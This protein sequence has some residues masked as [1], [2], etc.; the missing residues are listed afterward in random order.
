MN[1]KE[2]PITPEEKKKD[3]NRSIPSRESWEP[4]QQEPDKQPY[5]PE[6]DP[7]DESI[8]KT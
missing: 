2:K 4:N 7:D 8:R 3:F 1:N 5:I 6:R